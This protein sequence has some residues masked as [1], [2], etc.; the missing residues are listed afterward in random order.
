MPSISI[1]YG[2]HFQSG[3][4]SCR[5]SVSEFNQR[6][7]KPVER[8]RTRGSAV[9]TNAVLGTKAASQQT[10]VD[11]ASHCC[12][13]CNTNR[14]NAQERVTFLIDFVRASRLPWMVVETRQS[15]LSLEELAERAQD[16]LSSLCLRSKVRILD[17]DVGQ[18]RL[19]SR[20]GYEA[21]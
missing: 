8:E 13:L 1:D 11:C 20:R 10:V 4:H 18:Y 12:L 9:I 7:R 3:S 21:T 5:S 16:G 19:L 6:H 17:D 2:G 14:R 15:C